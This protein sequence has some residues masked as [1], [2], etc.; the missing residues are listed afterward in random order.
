MQNLA[1]SGVSASQCGQRIDGLSCTVMRAAGSAYGQKP[2]HL[3]LIRVNGMVCQYSRRALV[4]SEK[5]ETA[6]KPGE[7]EER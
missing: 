4:S 5:H 3:S 6:T 7:K 1:P 2:R